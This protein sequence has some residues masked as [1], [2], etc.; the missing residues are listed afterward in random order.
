LL[1]DPF[2]GEGIYYALWSGALAGKLICESVLK[3]TTIYR[4]YADLVKEELDR[5]FKIAQKI[6][7]VAYRIPW[8][9]RYFRK[10]MSSI[11]KML[12]YSLQHGKSYS[13]FVSSVKRRL[14]DL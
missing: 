11:L 4:E 14:I 13:T 7:K 3:G 5:E 1:A 8:F 9:L 12:G 6:A 10:S 2:L